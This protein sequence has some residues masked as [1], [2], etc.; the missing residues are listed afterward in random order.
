MLNLVKIREKSQILLG[1]L[2]FFFILSMTA[3]GLV[4]GANIMD[5]IFD[6][7]DNG[8]RYVGKVG[9]TKITRQQFLNAR[10]NQLSRLRQ[11]NTE[12]TNSAIVNAENNAWNTIVDETLVNEKVKSMGLESFDDEIYNFMFFTPPVSLQN[13]LTEAGFFMDADNNFDIELYQNA[14]S[15]GTYEVDPSFWLAWENYLKTFLPN[16]KL[17]NIYNLV[18]SVSNEDVKNEYIKRNI[19]CKIEYIYVNS[20]NVPDSLIQISEQDIIQN[21]NENKEE[22]YLIEKSKKIEYVLFENANPRA[23]SRN[24][25]TT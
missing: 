9:S 3:G 7:G 8:G 1:T 22:R 19:N 24:E 25:K 6:K 21:Y 16:R 12:I 13:Q 15:T 2:L 5:I 18:G 10:S 4:G 20:N 17:Q 11:Q 14:L 23:N